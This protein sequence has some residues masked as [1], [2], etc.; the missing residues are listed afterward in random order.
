[1]DV[2]RLTSAE[3]EQGL[4]VA[5]LAALAVGDAAAAAEAIDEAIEAGLAQMDLE[6]LDRCE[7]L[8][9]I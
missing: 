8:D 5:A 9:A 3:R 1:V 4:G 6:A 2:K 7:G